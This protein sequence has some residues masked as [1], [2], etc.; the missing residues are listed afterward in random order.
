MKQLVKAL[1]IILCVCCFASIKVNGVDEYTTLNT[2]NGSTLTYKNTN[3]E[4]KI[5]KL[6][7]YKTNETEFRGVWVSA[8]AGDI[9][10][11]TSS[12]EACQ[13]ELT[14]VLDLM[15]KYNLNTIL[16]HIR[17]HNDAFYNTNL[18]PKSNYIRACDFNKWD[19]LEWFINECHKRGI[20]FHAWM[21]PYRISSTK[22]TLQEVRSRFSSYPLNPA[23]S[24]NNILIGQSGAILDPGSPLVRNYL[25]NVCL[26]VMKKYDV[27]AIHFDDYFYIEGVDDSATFN[28]YKDDF[29]TDNLEEFRRL[30]VDKFIE[31]L[32]SA[33]YEFNIE[34]NRAVQLGISP[35]GVYRNGSY[36]TNYVY[37]DNGTLIS[38]VASNSTGYSHYDSPLY[39]DTKKWIDNEWID[40]IIPQLYGSFE[41]T[42]MPYADMVDWWTQVV[43]YKKVNLYTGIGLYQMNGTSDKGWYTKSLNTFTNQLLYNSKFE[44]VKGAC[45]YSYSTLEGNGYSSSDI[46]YV[47]EHM[48]KNKA[49]NPESRR[50]DYDTSDINVTLLKGEYSYT[51]LI[52]NNDSINRYAIYKSVNDEET[53]IGFIGNNNTF[54]KTSFVDEVENN[55]DITYRIFPISKSNKKGNE[56]IVYSKDAITNYNLPIGIVPDLTFSGTVGNKS[57][58]TIKINSMSLLIGNNVTYSLLMSYDGKEYREIKIFNKVNNYRGTEYTYE[59]NDLIKPNYFMIEAYNDYGY[60]RSEVLKVD[61]NRIKA[62]VFFEAQTRI[63]NNKLDEII[64]LEE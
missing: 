30:Q 25:I 40:Y 50:Y 29:N 12:K 57:R 53:L 36:N 39:S 24:D 64:N 4:V 3:I 43:K 62:S 9:N 6:E 5:P 1:I 7:N 59:F 32:S 37:D 8:F 18:A 28:Q 60:I 55:N 41:N 38:P 17:T 54:D 45:I 21:N 23:S 35:S 20:E 26:E 33:M 51:I 56:Y 31:D 42:G 22:T 27:D 44:E 52:D 61:Y 13:E 16:F 19:Y 2:S 34:N 49:Y 15:E 10:G 63:F 58:I 11:Y 48:W 14:S 47:N 46:K